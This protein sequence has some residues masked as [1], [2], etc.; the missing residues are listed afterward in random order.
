[1]SERHSTIIIC[2]CCTGQVEVELEGEI[3]KLKCLERAPK[4]KVMDLP[5]M[6]SEI[7]TIDQIRD[8]QKLDDLPRPFRT[9]YLPCWKPE[10]TPGVAIP[11]FS[12]IQ[13]LDQM[14]AK[15]EDED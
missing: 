11:D 2:P 9:S 5:V 15:D 6:T 1:M 14:I 13:A 8:E 3:Y 10:P 7:K 12:W 4:R